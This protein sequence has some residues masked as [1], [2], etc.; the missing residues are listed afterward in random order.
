MFYLFFDFF[1]VCVW[2]LYTVL[3][4]SSLFFCSLKKKWN[5]YIFSYILISISNMI[6]S[7]QK[8]SKRRR[9]TCLR[10]GSLYLLL[11]FFPC[12]YFY[13][14]ISYWESNLFGVWVWG[15]FFLL[16]QHYS[17]SLLR[18]HSWK[19]KSSSLLQEFLLNLICSLFCC[20][21]SENFILSLSFAKTTKS[22]NR[23]RNILFNF[24]WV[25]SSYFIF[26]SRMRE[27]E[28]LFFFM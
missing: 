25:V 15:D 5:L 6:W 22:L 12:L 1:Y 23:T 10:N 26:F 4:S 2:D 20:C 19:L 8:K 7:K 17:L 9:C 16:Q 24:C 27:R 11:R 14:Y 3:H 28:L 13:L 21:L 18:V